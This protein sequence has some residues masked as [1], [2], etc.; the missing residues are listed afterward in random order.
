[1]FEFVGKFEKSFLWIDSQL[2]LM[3]EVPS[4]KNEKG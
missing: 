3:S 2:M 4:L 1:M